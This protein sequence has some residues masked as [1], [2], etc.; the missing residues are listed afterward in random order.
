MKKVTIRIMPKQGVL[1][2]QGQA[3]RTSLNTLGFSEVKDVQTGKLVELLMENHEDIDKRV[4]EM[5]DTLLANPV[6]EDYHYEVEE[7]AHT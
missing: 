1:D 7:V 3:I 4:G 6:M 2:P 5:C